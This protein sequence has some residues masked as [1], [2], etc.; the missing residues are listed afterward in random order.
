[1]TVRDELIATGR[2]DLAGRFFAHMFEFEAI[3]Q[4]QDLEP[5]LAA[6][7]EESEYPEGT[8]W[9]Y[10]RF[11]WPEAYDS[12]MRL[13]KQAQPFFK[14][15]THVSPQHSGEPGIAMKYHPDTG[16]GSGRERVGQSG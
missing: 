11:L 13:L 2:S 6:C 9:C 3:K 8:G 5:F 16:R 7:D 1:M 4:S 10:T 12:G 15:F 14:A